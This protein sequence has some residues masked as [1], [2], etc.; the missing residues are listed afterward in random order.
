MSQPLLSIGMIVK[1]EERCLEK[2]LK[3]L[4]PL[5][6]A[7]PCELVIADTGST[8]KTKDIASKY[9]DA[10]FDFPWVNDFSKARNAVIAKCSGKWFLYLDADE[11][12]SSDVT[13]L[14]NLVTEK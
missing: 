3:A 14:T 7:I 2:C 8:D 12:L 9:A 11:Y 10:L 1:N 5:R 4:E 6:Q 13:E